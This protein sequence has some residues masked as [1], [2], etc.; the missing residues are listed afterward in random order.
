MIYAT[1]CIVEFD[2]E[3]CRLYC[4]AD[5]SKHGLA[6]KITEHLNDQFE[7]TLKYFSKTSG[8]TLT[9]NTSN[10]GYELERAHGQ[11]KM[12]TNLVAKVD[13]YPLSHYAKEDF[14]GNCE[15]FNGKN[16]MWCC[17]GPYVEGLPAFLE[18]ADLFLYSQGL[19]D[20]LPKDFMQYTDEEQAFQVVYD[21]LE[22][23]SKKQKA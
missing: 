17:F 16:D 8:K 12:F 5:P 6:K 2:N 9:R 21:I 22:R 14:E 19:W 18:E 13:A 20:E 1:F 11:L 7:V 4:Y 23:W 15:F 10:L 3:K